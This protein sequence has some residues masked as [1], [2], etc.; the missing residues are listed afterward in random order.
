[1]Q[2]E[3]DAIKF[4]TVERKIQIRGRYDMGKTIITKTENFTRKMAINIGTSIA[5]QDKVGQKINSIVAAAVVTGIDRETGEE[6]Q[7]SVLVDAGGMF[8][9]A[10]SATV[11]EQ[12]DDIIELIDDG[13]DFDV[14]V[15]SRTSKGG[16][17]FITLNVV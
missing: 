13:E 8:Y 11:L 4:N 7:V 3:R 6:K 17:D 2:R 12:M 5:L 1:M 9:S 10:I 16:R 15:V 14:I